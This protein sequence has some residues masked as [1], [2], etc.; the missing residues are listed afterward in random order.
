M[1]QQNNFEN[2]LEC[3]I[4]LENINKNYLIQKDC[5]CNINIHKKCFYEWNIKNP[6]QCPLC[7]IELNKNIII[8]INPTNLLNTEEIIHG[9]IIINNNRFH[10]ESMSKKKKIIYSFLLSFIFFGILI[11]IKSVY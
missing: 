7:R 3:I 5:K 11:G 4:C 9:K 6:N 10:G 1:D 2:N 8:T